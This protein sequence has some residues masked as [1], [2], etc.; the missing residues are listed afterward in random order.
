MGA[1]MGMVLSI[2]TLSVVGLGAWDW[3][4]AAVADGREM[5]TEGE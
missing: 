1:T 3:C 2:H 4:F 5:A